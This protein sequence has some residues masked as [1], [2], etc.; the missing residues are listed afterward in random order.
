MKQVGDACA[1]AIKATHGVVYD[2]GRI[3][4]IIY[5]ASG[6]SVDYVY[7]LTGAISFGVELRDT[8][9]YGFLLPPNQIIPTGE[10]N[11]AA[12]TVLAKHVLE[13]A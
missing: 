4:I 9:R 12:V 2:S 3:S 1:A 8:G 7:G 13:S 11:W 5:E 6:S 10:E